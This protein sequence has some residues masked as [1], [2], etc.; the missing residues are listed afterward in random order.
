[1]KTFCLIR[2]FAVFL[3]VQLL[4]PTASH[5]ATA[6]TASMMSA[7][8]RPLALVP[9][10]L[11][12]KL[13]RTEE[14]G[15]QTVVWGSLEA[16]LKFPE[17]TLNGSKREIKACGL[18]REV[19]YLGVFTQDVYGP[20][21][22]QLE[23]IGY[24][25]G[26]T[27]LVFDY[28]WRL[29]VLENANLLGGY[30]E[31]AVSGHGQVDIVAHSMGGLIAR[32]YALE[33][34]GATRIN[35]LITAGAPW[36]GSVEVFD[37]LENGWG[38]ANLLMGGLDGFRR[39]ILSFP[40]MYE[41]MPS[42]SGCCYRADG[43]PQG[44][45]PDRPEAWAD[46][47]WEGIDAELLPD[48]ADLKTRQETLR[49]IAETSLPATIEEV[50]VIGVD[51]RTPEQ[52]Q[53]K[54]GNGPA[55]FDIRTSWNGDGTVMTDSALLGKRATFRTSFAAHN[56][57]LNEDTVQ[58]FITTALKAGTDT[59]VEEVPVRERTS[60]LT[61]LGEA[62]EL[63]GVVLETDQPIYQSDQSAKAIVHLRLGEQTPLAPGLLDLNV[64][65][66]GGRVFPVT[67]SPD[68]AASDPFNPFEQSFS[69]QIETGAVAG[70]L[71]LTLTLE[72]TG[73]QPR[74][75]TL[76]VPVVRR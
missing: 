32:A 61:A 72:G 51:Q 6:A 2:V 22:E 13:C 64:A 63:V 18:I 3:S 23:A 49:R 48:L 53:L 68:P 35:R 33:E 50:L 39:T 19:S 29:S 27:L 25:E 15:R 1:M 14:D 56:S 43:N 42:Y 44:F 21:I 54:T 28:D 10:L 67:L 59:A 62:V 38:A 17:L 26:T 11:G 69:A 75:V 76:K 70:E 58:D 47:N 46:L 9:G 57:I 60:I 41:L 40:S 73:A 45:E 34:G 74:M 16:I 71:L 4:L 66:P 5:E 12:S 24:Q 55:R 8:Q 20:F 7:P 36:R 30:I 65:T 37:L 31:Q 52:Y